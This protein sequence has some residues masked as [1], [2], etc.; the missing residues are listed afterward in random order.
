MQNGSSANISTSV[1]EGNSQEGM[2]SA[3]GSGGGAL[4]LESGCSASVSESAFSANSANSGGAILSQGHLLLEHT[5]LLSNTAIKDAGAMFFGCVS[6]PDSCS[7]TVVMC[8]FIQNHA[9]SVSFEEGGGA[10][11]VLSG[12]LSLSGSIFDTNSIDGV[13]F[14]GAIFVKSSTN[15]PVMLIILNTSFRGSKYSG[16][17][18]QA[19]ATRRSTNEITS[20]VSC[21]AQSPHLTQLP[22]LVC[23]K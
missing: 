15:K 13:G 19:K 20:E 6:G 10:I 22:L 23:L 5:V 18:R 11:F 1:F 17:K 16:D 12:S 4:Y 9:S 7:C 3:F 14:G 21:V 8:T 2:G